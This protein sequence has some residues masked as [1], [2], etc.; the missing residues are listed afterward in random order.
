ME[1]H[2]P[3]IIYF[4]LYEEDL[5]NSFGSVQ[6][7]YK[8][9]SNFDPNNQVRKSILWKEILVVALAKSEIFAL[10]K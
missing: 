10:A 2:G 4:Q 1:K 8:V 9:C 6:E 7:G 5:Q 3:K